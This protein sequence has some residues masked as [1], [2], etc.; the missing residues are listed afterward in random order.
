M[1]LLT[2]TWNMETIFIAE[3]TIQEQYM[4]ERQLL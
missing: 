2:S 3:A 4:N 1:Q